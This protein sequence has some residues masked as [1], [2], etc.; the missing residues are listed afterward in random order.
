MRMLP[1]RGVPAWAGDPVSAA[2]TVGARPEPSG[3]RLSPGGREAA[4]RPRRTG[5]ATARASDSVEC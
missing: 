4:R 3:G 1:P 5:K 2:R